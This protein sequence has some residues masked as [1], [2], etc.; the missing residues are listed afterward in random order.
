MLPNYDGNR[1]TSCLVDYINDMADIDKDHQER[2]D[3]LNKDF[4]TNL[5]GI[6]SG[7][8]LPAALDDLVDDLQVDRG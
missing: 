1:L 3:E 4:M 7:Q 5:F 2:V 8:S 6:D